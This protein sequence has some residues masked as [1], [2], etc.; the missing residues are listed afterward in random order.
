MAFLKCG[1]SLLALYFMAGRAEGADPKESGNTVLAW[2]RFDE[3]GQDYEG[4]RY[5]FLGDADL[6]LTFD[7]KPQPGHFIELL[8]GAKDD[9]RSALMT[10]NKR[11][12][13]L[14]DGGYK[15]YRWLQTPIPEGAP[16]E[17]YEITL[18]SDANGKPAF[19]A[20]IRLTSK[21]KPEGAAPDMK[22]VSYRAAVTT[23][24]A[25]GYKFPARGVAVGEAFPEMRKIWDREPSTP[26]L[27]TADEA[28]FRQAERNARSG[29]EGLYRC[30]RYIDGWLAHADPET[31]LIP[32]NLRESNYWNGRDSGA[33]NYPFMVLTASI[34]DRPL[35]QG[36][37]LDILKT[38]TRLTSRVDHLPDD[39]SFSK[40]GWRRE[41]LDLDAIIFDGAEYVKDGLI[42]LTE[43]LG[44]S[45]WSER[46]TGITDDIWKNAPIDTPYGKIPTLNFEVNGDLLQACT[47]IYWFTGDRKYLDWAMRLGDYYLLGQNHPTRNMKELRLMD[48]GCEVINGLSELYVAVSQVAPEKKKAYQEPLHAIYDKVL[49]IGRNEDGL[50]Y[51]SINP[52]TGGHSGGLC[53]TWGYNY[54]GFYTMY[55]V[56]KTEAYRD[57][58]RKALGNLKGK[59]IGACWADKSADGFAD[60]IEGAINLFNREAI[61]SAADWIDSQIRMMWAIQK[62][63]GV[64]EAWHGDGNFARTT[65]MYVLMKAQGVHAEPWRA[66]VRVGAVRQD[67][68]GLAGQARAA[69]DG[70][71]IMISLAADEAWSGRLIFDKP[72]HKIN[73]HLPMDYPRI[74]QFPEWFTTEADRRYVISDLAGGAAKTVTGK[75]LQEGIALELKPG[76]EK[77][78][79][80]MSKC[81]RMNVVS[82]VQE[83]GR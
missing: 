23:S 16:G 11:E 53:D 39:Y 25:S 5:R 14:K 49:E 69:R 3:G 36:R 71:V 43:W 55:L 24:A 80:P 27:M 4:R 19:I 15:G 44:R 10:V 34:T 65:L 20:E 26:T 6:Q 12:I 77:L 28:L 32:R 81:L 38:E 45:P 76:V 52:Q 54:D 78:A 22:A 62:S 56:D 64:I 70:S 60:S 31:G 21:S 68:P 2:I 48:H 9:T 18:K 66:D 74:N 30:R 37:L 82:I 57:A 13:A 63:D 75:D 33:D 35:M 7:V 51:A 58:V 67:Q 59:Y 47:R 46:M 83:R 50:L 1:G 17:R 40:K 29:A 8:W 42:P 79:Q 41:K 73:M 72:R 61:P